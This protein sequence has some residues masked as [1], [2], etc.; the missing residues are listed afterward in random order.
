MISYLAIHKAPEE[1]RRS[2]AF[3]SLMRNHMRIAEK[4]LA[5]ALQLARNAGVS[6]PMGS[7]VSQ[8]M[9]RLYGVEDENR[10]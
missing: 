1:A 4:D 3:Q 6:L 9:A 7:L 5:W 2:S 8:L 10:R